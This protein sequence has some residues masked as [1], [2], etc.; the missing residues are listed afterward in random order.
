MGRAALAEQVTRY[1]SAAL[2][3]A[4]QTK[5][6]KGKLMKK[7]RALVRRLLGRQDDYLRFTQ[8]RRVPLDNNGRER[9]IRMAELKQKVSGS[10]RTWQAPASSAPSPRRWL[11]EARGGARCKRALFSCVS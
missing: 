6:R 8:D 11:P 4:S 5:A 7:H 1:R 9:D 2:I 10:L 3:G